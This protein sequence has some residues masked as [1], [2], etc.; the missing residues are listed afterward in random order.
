MSGYATTARIV[1]PAVRPRITTRPA[2]GTATIVVEAVEPWPGSRGIAER[3]EDWRVIWRQT[4][5]YLFDP[6][7]WL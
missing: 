5:F 6:M 4:T 1:R 7:A 3:L 2:G